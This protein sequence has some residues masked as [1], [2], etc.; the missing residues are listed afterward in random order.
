MI[1]EL[2]KRLR[3]ATIRPVAAMFKLNTRIKHHVS[4]IAAIRHRHLMDL[5]LEFVDVLYNLFLSSLR[6]SFIPSILPFPKCWLGANDPS[7]FSLLQCG[8]RAKMLFY[9][10][11][12]GFRYLLF[13]ITFS[14][15]L[16]TTIYRQT[17]ATICIQSNQATDSQHHTNRLVSTTNVL[18]SGGNLGNRER[19]NRRTSAS[20]GF[21]ACLLFF[22]C[23][24]RSHSTTTRRRLLGHQRASMLVVEKK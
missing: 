4:A 13:F 16:M 15:F 1:L 5:F 6:L 21:G 23:S 20:W 7:T 17:A 18:G 10:R 19:R 14:T 11:H 2:E 9:C 8:W 24:T 22:F 3:E 12:L